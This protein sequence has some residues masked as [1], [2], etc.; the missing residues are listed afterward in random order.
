MEVM[1]KNDIEKIRKSSKSASSSY[2][3]WTTHYEEMA[4][5]TVIR[6]LCKYLPS[7]P[8]LNQAVIL[9]EK[10]DIGK[11]NLAE[12]F[13]IVDVEVEEVEYENNVEEK[14]T[15]EMKKALAQE[16]MFTIAE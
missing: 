14:Q 13:D 12:D 3:P 16:G 9:D 11:Q 6:R 1:F 15:D 5:K 4:R 7:S 8:E 2:S 10:A